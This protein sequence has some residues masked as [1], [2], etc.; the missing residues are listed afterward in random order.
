MMDD[1][2]D[3]AVPFHLAK[4]LDQHF[5]RDSRDCAFQVGKA[6][7]LAAEKMKQDHKLPPALQQLEGLF[8]ALGGGRC[9]VLDLTQKSVPY[10]FVRSCHLV[11]VTTPLLRSNRGR[12]R[13]LVRRRARRKGTLMPID[14]SK[15]I[16]AYFTADKSDSEAVA[17]CFT[18][19]ATVKD[20]GHT[21]RG[22]DAIKRWKADSAT[23]YSYTSEPFAVEHKDGRIVVTSHLVG[24]FPGSPVDL[25]YFFVLDGDKI[26]SLEIVP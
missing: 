21:Y 16:V 23:R 1:P 11:S 18:D 10:F 14:L 15:P 2:P 12:G 3:N 13:D 24:D 19:H 26:A 5:L 22:R 6:Q 17:R 8:N 20:E 9:G 4:L 25:R 7:Q